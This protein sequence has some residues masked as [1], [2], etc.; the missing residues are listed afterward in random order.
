MAPFSQKLPANTTFSLATAPDA[1]FSVVVFTSVVLLVYRYNAQRQ[2]SKQDS[3]LFPT[4]GALLKRIT[5]VLDT[6]A[7]TDYHAPKAAAAIVR[8]LQAVW[9]N[10]DAMQVQEDQEAPEAP[11]HTHLHDV[12]LA[13]NNAEPVRYMPDMAFGSYSSSTL[14][15]NVAALSSLPDNSGV[16]AAD[17]LAMPAFGAGLDL[18]SLLDTMGGSLDIDELLLQGRPAPLPQVDHNDPLDHDFWSGFMATYG[19]GLAA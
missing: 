4:T 19:T 10:M 13:T 16:G 9:D 14:E 15:S 17:G 1:V 3:P 6:L 2:L 12:K 8:E 18:Q 5:H 11:D 7:L